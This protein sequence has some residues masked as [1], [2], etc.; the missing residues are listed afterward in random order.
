MTVSS[1]PHTIVAIATPP[2]TGAIG[3]VRLSGPQAGTYLS[4]VWKNKAKS[5]DKFVTRRIYYGK[6]AEFSTEEDAGGEIIDDVL[7]VYFQ[8]PRSYTGEDL[9]EVYAHGSP[10][11]LERIVM[12]FVRLGAQPARPGEFTERAFLNGRIDLVQAEAVADLI[13]STSAHAHRC[14]TEQLQGR[15]SRIVRHELDALTELRA[16]VEAT[17]DFPE[18]D[19]ALLTRARVGE[20]LDAIGARLHALGATYQEGRLYREGVR[21]VLAGRPNAGKSSLL[22]AL[23]GE[24]RAIVHHQPGTTR[25]VIE[26]V[27]RLD[28][29]AIRLVDTAG[30]RNDERVSPEGDRRAVTSDGADAVEALGM[31]RTQAQVQ[32]ADLLLLVIDGSVPFT[33]GEREWVGE[34]RLAQVVIAVNKCDLPQA[35]DAQAIA[36]AFPDAPILPIS[37]TRGDGLPAL[38]AALIARAKGGGAEQAEGSVVTNVRHKAAVDTATAAIMAARRTVADDLAA[39]FVAEHL[40]R[41]SEALGEIVGTVTTDD[42]LRQIFS[43]FCIG[44]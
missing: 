11:L 26:E 42:L 41:A 25:D 27:A 12:Q 34:E 22:N 5:V 17:I 24:E 13:A 8:R 33:G 10:Y 28:G 30:L 19:I 9:V 29:I 7:A 35:A 6:I 15:L 36:T 37:A 32:C 39:E 43:R 20:R 21:V 4:Q 3:I 1:Q 2:G 44:K 23:L 16:F 18:E 38:T 40:R 31:Q 14:A